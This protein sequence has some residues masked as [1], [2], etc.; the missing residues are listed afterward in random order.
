MQ[1]GYLLLAG[2][3]YAEIHRRVIRVPG[4]PQKEVHGEQVLHL[5]RSG[6]PGATPGLSDAL[7]LRPF[8]HPRQQHQSWPFNIH[9][10]ALTEVVG[11]RAV[12]TPGQC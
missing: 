5:K 11:S 8:G 6:Q 3:Q 9:P 4:T 10:F 2:L 7:G 1:P 12:H